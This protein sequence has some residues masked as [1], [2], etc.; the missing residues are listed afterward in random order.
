V[1]ENPG[2]ARAARWRLGAGAVVVLVLA[3]IGVTVIVG[4]V[5]G[6]GDGGEVVPVPTAA[7]SAPARLSYVHVAGAVARPGLYGLPADAR[8]VDAIS[9]AGGFTPDAA[10]EAVNLARAVQDGEQLLVPVR[11][12]DPASGTTVGTGRVNVN[13][14]NAATLDSLPGIGPAIADRIVS[15]REKNGRFASVD[16]LLSVPGIGEKLLEGLR[17]LVSV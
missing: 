7:T 11:G 15:W 5:R 8:V 13:T 10:Q 16:D 12:A 6:G 14:A 2:P 9:A 1:I 3:V 4:I 17:D